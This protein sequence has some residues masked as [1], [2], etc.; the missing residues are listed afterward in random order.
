MLRAGEGAGANVG[1][2]GCNRGLD[3]G[4]KLAIALD[5]FRHPRGE[6]EH[7]LKHEDL[8]VAGHASAD[9]D[10]WDVDASRDAAGER[11]G[12]RLNHHGKGARLSNRPGIVLDRPP[13]RLAATLS[14]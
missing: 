2:V 4:P 7:V 5:E 11:L 6:P 14:T 12:H 13:I 9:A 8:A 1:R 3:G 10:G